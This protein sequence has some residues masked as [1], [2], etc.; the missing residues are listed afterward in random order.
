[1]YRSATKYVLSAAASVPI[2]STPCRLSRP[3][4]EMM[5][6][7]PFRF[8]SKNLKGI[9]GIAGIAR[10]SSCVKIGEASVAMAITTAMHFMI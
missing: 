10:A 4:T 8:A 3:L 2:E 9:N 6:R 7:H 1:L 5:T